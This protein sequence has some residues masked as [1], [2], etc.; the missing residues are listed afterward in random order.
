MGGERREKEGR[1]RKRR[2]AEKTKWG[3]ERVVFH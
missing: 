3:G 2:E 1:N